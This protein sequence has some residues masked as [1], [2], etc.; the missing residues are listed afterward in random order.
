MTDATA[1]EIKPSSGIPCRIAPPPDANDLGMLPTLNA[2]LV[3]VR[4]VPA[5]QDELYAYVRFK[6][7]DNRHGLWLPAKSVLMLPAGLNAK[8][9]KSI[10]MFSVKPTTTMRNLIY[11]EVGA[12]MQRA[13]EAGSLMDFLDERL[14]RDFLCPSGIRYFHY[15]LGQYTFA[16]WYFSPF[17][18]VYESLSFPS[19][20][21]LYDIYLCPFTLRCYATQEDLMQAM[22]MLPITLSPE[23]APPLEG[24]QP[25]KPAGKKSN[26]GAKHATRSAA[27]P[28]E[29]P[30]DDGLCG[31]ELLYGTLADVPNMT[32]RKLH[33]PGTEIYRDN[34]F[35][36]SLFEVRGH[37]QKEYGRNLF[38]I[39]KSFLENKLAGHDVDLYVFYVLCLHC[40]KHAPW[41]MGTVLDELA[42]DASERASIECDV[43]PMIFAGYYSWEEGL[44][45]DNLACI[46][47]LPCFASM[48]L[49]HFLIAAS[50]EMSYRR[51]C[52][53]TPERPLSDLGTMAYRLYWREV[54]FTWF[55]FE[56][57]EYLDSNALVLPLDEATTRQLD[58]EERR[59]VEMEMRSRGPPG[60][61]STAKLGDDGGSSVRTLSK[62]HEEKRAALLT[63]RGL[64]VN[65]S[66]A[67]RK[68]SYSRRALQ[69]G[70][71]RKCLAYLRHAHS[72][73]TAIANTSPDDEIA[74]GEEG[75]TQKRDSL[76]IDDE[77]AGDD[78][79]DGASYDALDDDNTVKKPKQKATLT[80]VE[81]GCVAIPFRLSVPL[82]AE[83]TKLEE[84]DVIDCLHWC[85]ILHKVI[86]SPSNGA[87]SSSVLTIKIPLLHVVEVLQRRLSQGD[88]L[89][90]VRFDPKRLTA[91]PKRIR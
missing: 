14:R 57:A 61:S 6:D 36:A 8:D 1:A 17:Y 37:E 91:R 42:V 5:E 28:T 89:S 43:D 16:P 39:G 32:F 81:R 11:T 82:V 69:R 40:Q 51:G 10:S 45:H 50:Y 4:R 12:D 52:V 83:E 90:V 68:W 38:L 33:P 13:K 25:Q 55:A 44:V 34:V 72:H 65:T 7:H 56:L 86:T 67:T 62:R 88:N 53:G 18:V 9:A 64:A 71:T 70:I 35:G 85:G 49:G 80:F 22:Q 19:N 47:T 77:N 2:I 74:K 15:L 75:D 84:G 31:P 26:Q 29:I 3:E 78:D 24:S 41:V 54:L 30:D 79:E 73:L 48:G 76:T 21:I 66:T 59:V 87:A 60:A 27:L 46:M 63:Q 20:D 23:Y 58:E